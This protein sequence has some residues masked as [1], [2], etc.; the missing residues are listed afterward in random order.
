MS[1]KLIINPNSGKGSALKKS[2]SVIAELEKRDIEFDYE[3]TNGPREAVRIAREASAKYEKI[4]AVGGDGTVN[5]VG[6]GVVGTDSI[7][8]VI[9]L[10]SGNDFANELKIPSKIIS[11]VDLLLQ[12]SVRT[13]DVIR[14]NDRVSLNTAGVGFNALVSENVGQ[15]KYLRGLSVYIW[16]VVKSAVRYEA[17]PLK[18]AINN[19]VID[20][21]I[22]MVSICNSKSEGGGF[23]VAPD[24]INDDG[25]FDVTVIRDIGYLKLL[26]NITNA[27][28][29]KLNKMDEVETI[30][31]DKITIESE[32]PMPLHVDGEV[33]SMNS[34][35]VEASILKGALR[36]IGN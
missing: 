7:F 32:F 12:G 9:P 2:Q 1:I 15:I 18:I 33:L 10:G 22:F 26:L 35:Y 4:V 16:G 34:N 13:I 25:F 36:V 20:E 28:N 8:C 5:E 31:S 11:A 30:R 27:L 3:I 14:V 23:V 24:A 19:K 6:E 21:K 17:I 29:G